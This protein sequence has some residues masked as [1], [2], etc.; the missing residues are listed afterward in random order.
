MNYSLFEKDDETQ[1]VVSLTITL[2]RIKIHLCCA[3]FCYFLPRLSLGWAY[4][5]PMDIEATTP[6]PKKPDIPLR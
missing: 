2:A 5:T 3:I 4:C 6:A 1:I